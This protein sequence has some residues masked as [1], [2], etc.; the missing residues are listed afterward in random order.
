MAKVELKTYGDVKKVINKMTKTNIFNNVKGV[1]ADE[2][3]NI[4]VDIVGAIFPGVSAAKKAYDVFKAFASKPDTKKTDTWLDKLD[5]G[6]ETAAIVDDT[7]EAGFF[8]ELA[9]TL[10]R[11]PDDTPLDDSF[12][13][14][15]RFQEYLQNKYKNHYVAPVTENKMNKAQLRD[16]IIEAYVQALTEVEAPVLKTSTQEILGKFPTVK[17]TLVSLFTH[18]FDE[19][20]EDVKWTVPK[21][22]TFMVALK[23]GQTFDLKWTG[24]GFEANIEGK[25]YFLNNTSEYQ[26]ALDSINRILK[27]GPIS[28]G[29]EPGGD[30]FAA[31]PPIDAAAPAAGGAE[32]APADFGAE[33]PGAEGG[34]AEDET[35]TSL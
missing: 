11:I 9:D 2:G 23:N 7:V 21:P 25:R 8:Q 24:K 3:V 12:S 17:K 31:E 26:Q 1:L 20:V 10:A 4:A 27:D 35:P 18:E 14:E 33:E 13:M 32:E 19:F 28:Q 22:S 15:K 5:I 6:D 30:A 29:E 34:G 16:I